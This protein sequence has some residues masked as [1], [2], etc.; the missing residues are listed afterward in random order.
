MTQHVICRSLIFA[1]VGRGGGAAFNTRWGGRSPPRIRG[2]QS[3]VV[4]NR[5]GEQ[6]TAA[7]RFKFGS[8]RAILLSLHTQGVYIFDVELPAFCLTAVCACYQ[9][10][11]HIRLPLCKPMQVH[12]LRS[13]YQHQLP[14]DFGEKK[15]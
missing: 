13:T 12:A 14:N 11:T 10:C 6:A 3:S 7:Y 8:L 4:I 9:H 1:L 15:N 5:T 2:C